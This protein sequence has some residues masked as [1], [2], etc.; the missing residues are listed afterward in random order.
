MGAWIGHVVKRRRL[1]KRFRYVGIRAWIGLVASAVFS[2]RAPYVPMNKVWGLSQA[3]S[4]APRF[5]GALRIR[6]VQ[7][8][9][10]AW[11]QALQYRDEISLGRALVHVWQL[12]HVQCM[13]AWGKCF[14]I[15]LMYVLA[16]SL[17]LQGILE[18]V[19][20]AGRFLIPLF[21]HL[22]KNNTFF[23]FTFNMKLALLNMA[24]A[25]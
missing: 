3:G 6:K 8:S 12:N 23:F 11:R 21:F 13:T 20:E 14:N 15:V 9:C 22:L 19:V 4:E 5:W 1:V 16:I 25:C 17:M 18:G 7:G 2:G 24:T 10:E